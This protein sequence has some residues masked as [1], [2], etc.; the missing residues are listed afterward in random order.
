MG[1][2]LQIGRHQKMRVISISL[3]CLRLSI[4]VRTQTQASVVCTIQ[5]HMSSTHRRHGSPHRRT[6]LPQGFIYQS[7]SRHQHGRH[8]HHHLPPA[9]PPPRKAPLPSDLMPADPQ[10]TSFRPIIATSQRNQAAVLFLYGR[11][12][13][14]PSSL[15]HWSKYCLTFYVLH[16]HS[17]FIIPHKLH[18]YLYVY[19]FYSAYAPP[20]F[21]LDICALVVWRFKAI[22]ELLM[23]VIDIPASS[24]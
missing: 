1:S 20:S 23:H 9:S 2:G 8:H 13:Q 16:L 10:T 3:S 17:F 24:H 21:T 15:N 6:L 22:P 5:Y 14:E 19:L 12:T 7:P 18:L 4:P 11:F